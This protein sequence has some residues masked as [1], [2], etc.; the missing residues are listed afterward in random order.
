[1]GRLSDNAK[2]IVNSLGVNEEKLEYYSE[3]SPLI[4]AI[5]KLA[6]YEDLEEQG[7]LIEQK[8][9]KWIKKHNEK[10]WTHYTYSCSICDSGSD[11]DTN[12]CPNCG[13]KMELKELEE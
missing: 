12:Y 3:Y 9:G 10:S 7:R 5:N 8:R 2:D 6:H 4:D 1:M 13:A 11:C